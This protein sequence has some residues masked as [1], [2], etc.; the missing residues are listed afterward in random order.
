M[1]EKE[2]PF[3]RRAEIDLETFVDHKDGSCS[4][5]LLL[6]EKKSPYNTVR[7]KLEKIKPLEADKS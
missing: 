4:F 2:H 1:T 7:F 6:A 5:E 3:W